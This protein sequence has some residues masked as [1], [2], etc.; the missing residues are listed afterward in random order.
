MKKRKKIGKGKG[1]GNVLKPKHCVSMN[2][3]DFS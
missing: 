3:S 2:N 1:N